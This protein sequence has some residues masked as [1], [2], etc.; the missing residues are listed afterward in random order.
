MKS[1]YRPHNGLDEMIRRNGVAQYPRHA[2][3]QNVPAAI[4]EPEKTNSRF[5]WERGT[6]CTAVYDELPDYDKGRWLFAVVM[7][8]VLGDCS[9]RFKQHEPIKVDSIQHGE[10]LIKEKIESDPNFAL[11]DYLRKNYKDGVRI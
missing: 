6:Y 4:S 7:I 5:V 1:N 3:I 10:R 8:G 11:H 9:L 2:R